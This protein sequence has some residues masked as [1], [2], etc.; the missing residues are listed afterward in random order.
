[1]WEEN[2]KEKGQ[3]H[4]AYLFSIYCFLTAGLLF[5]PWLYTT[6][7]LYQFLV[8]I[9]CLGIIAAGITP[10]FKNNNSWIHY[11]GGIVALLCGLIWISLNSPF[12]IILISFLIFIILSF[13]KP[14]S[15]IFFG[16]VIGLFTLILVL[17][18]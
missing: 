7:I 9:G 10:F 14:N 8:F 2:C 11:I 12:I 16:E 1:M 5:F 18:I 3:W 17:L 6:P 4:T 15:Y 13:W